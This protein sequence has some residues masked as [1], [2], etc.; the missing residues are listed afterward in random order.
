M[1]TDKHVAV[2]V[3]GD[4]EKMRRHLSTSFTTVVGDN[5]LA[6]DGQATVRVDDD[7]EQSRVRL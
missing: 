1:L 4:G 3:V 6:V 2:S 5:V 7:A